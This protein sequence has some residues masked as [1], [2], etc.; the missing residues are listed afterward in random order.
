MTKIL[1]TL[2]FSAFLAAGDP[3]SR[4]VIISTPGAVV[5]WEGVELGET[6]ASGILIIDTVPQGSFEVEL[7]KDGHLTE[8]IA[9]V[10]EKPE[11]ILDRR[12]RPIRAPVA[13][14]RT[15]PEPAPRQPEPARQP[16][17]STKFAPPG[18][19]GPVRSEP[20]EEASVVAAD[21]P[22]PP[23]PSQ[24]IPPSPA[25]SAPA[26]QTAPDT[27]VWPLF[28]LLALAGGGAYVFY[29]RKSG[30]GRSRKARRRRGRSASVPR[31]EPKRGEKASEEVLE[32][33]RQREK[34]MNSS[35]GGD[36]VEVEFVEIVE[37]S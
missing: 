11:H 8:R 29:Q 34:A 12:L 5:T 16:E 2:V 35:V 32:E 10:V 21:T 30:A 27:P 26:F 33:L 15:E 17:P 9:L 18:P 23:S 13:P 19:T 1:A 20:V 28:L 25:A 3:P 14:R 24:E 37:E 6:N 36:V 4:V 7:A 22:Q 31:V